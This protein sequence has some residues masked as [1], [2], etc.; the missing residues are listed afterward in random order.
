MTSARCRCLPSS[1]FRQPG[2]AALRV[3]ILM[4]LI[5]VFTVPLPAQTLSVLHSFGGTLS[6]GDSPYAGVVLLGNNLYG[7]TTYG[8]GNQRVG[9]VFE[10]SH[11]GSGWVE[12]VLYDFQGG[13]DAALP[14][15]GVVAGPSGLLYGESYIGGIGFGTVYRLQPP[16]TACHSVSCPWIERVLYR[17]RGG[18]DGAYPGNAAAL[19]FDS[20]GNIYG[21]TAGS[22]PPD[23]YDN[24][25]V[26]EL[27]PANGGWTETVLHHFTN[28]ELPLAGVVFDAAGNLYGTTEAGG[29]GYGTVYE[30]SPSNG[31]WTFQTI[32][33]FQNLEDGAAPLG[34]LAVDPAGNLYGTTS[35]NGGTVFQLQPSSGGWSFNTIFSAFPSTLGPQDTPTLDSAGNV[36]GTVLNDHGSNFGLVFKLTPSGGSWIETNLAVFQNLGLAAFPYGSVV[37]DANGN[38]FG[39]SL[40]GGTF[41]DGTVWEITP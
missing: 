9:N 3:V 6:S 37:L 22:A 16:A 29:L 38:V 7:T 25:T 11:H 2:P 5:A 36:Y 10:L 17:F 19:T 33:Q 39:T 27:S 23:T 12:S 35:T 31:S 21:T 32:Y 28:G 18:S 8:G 40:E 24:G 20:A 26:F 4:T 1:A 14:Y 13:S 30:L 15:S 41:G 34:G